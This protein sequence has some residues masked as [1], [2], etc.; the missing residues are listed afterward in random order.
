MKVPEMPND[1]VTFLINKIGLTG[2]AK[3]VDVLATPSG[4]ENECFENVGNKVVSE[5]GQRII[6]WQIWET[7]YMIE[8]ELH[9]VWL[10]PSGAFFDVTPRKH[11]LNNILF[12][13]DPNFKYDGFQRDNIRINKTGNLLVDDYIKL[14]MAKFMLMNKGEK[15]RQTG[16]VSFIGSDANNW[17]SINNLMVEIENMLQKGQTR[18][19]VCFCSSGK[20]YKQCHGQDLSFKLELI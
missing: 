18:N 20:K 16:L 13:A 5:G 2:E 15:A 12:I 7:P 8:A 14:A 6:G 19:S 17:A 1:Y 10:T 9:A 4:E 11:L 3:Y